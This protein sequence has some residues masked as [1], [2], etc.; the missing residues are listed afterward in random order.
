LLSY[1]D[2]IPP[3]VC[4]QRQVDAI[5]FDL[6]SA[7]DIV[8]HTLLLHKLR[9]NGLPDSYVSWL[10]SYKTNRYSVARI[11]GI[12]P[13]AFEVL[14]GV[15]QESVLGHLLFSVFISDLCN[16]LKHSRYLSF[17]DDIKIYCT[18]SSVTDCTLL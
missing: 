8:S 16:F 12:C 2:Y 6:S 3:L 15:R 7:F 9:A 14:S 11:H 1:L 10:H 4:T 5:Y 13:T 17:A 18:L